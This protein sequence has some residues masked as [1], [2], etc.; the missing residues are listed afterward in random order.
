MSNNLDNTEYVN[1]GSNVEFPIELIPCENTRLS[2]AAHDIKKISDIC[3]HK[4]DIPI[5]RSAIADYIQAAG[6]Y[7][8]IYI[9]K[10]DD[11]GNPQD[12]IEIYH[13]QN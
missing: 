10:T 11:E 13:I 7:G 2:L 6:L 8:E 3:I 1:I 5:L 4:S 9:S 12:L